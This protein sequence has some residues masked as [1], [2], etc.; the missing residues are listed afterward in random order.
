[1]FVIGAYIIVAVLIFIVI[2]VVRRRAKKKSSSTWD[3]KRQFAELEEQQRQLC[4]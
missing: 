3:L 2:W 4:G 1:M